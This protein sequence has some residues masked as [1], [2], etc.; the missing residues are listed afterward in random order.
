MQNKGKW[1]KNRGGH[2]LGCSF[3][4]LPGGSFIWTRVH[5]RTIPLLTYPRGHFPLSKNQSVTFKKK[6]SGGRILV[7]FSI[8]G[9]KKAKK[10]SPAPSAPGFLQTPRGE[11]ASGPKTSQSLSKNQSLT[12]RGRGTHRAK[13]WYVQDT[14]HLLGGW[15]TL[16]LKIVWRT[17]LTKNRKDRDLWPCFSAAGHAASVEIITRA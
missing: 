3:R 10:F 16:S 7:T 1:L 14:G 17:M 9:L 11:G 4:A 8:K 13:Q 6:T 15:F 5:F 12:P 2:L